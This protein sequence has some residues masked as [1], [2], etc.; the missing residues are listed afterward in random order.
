MPAKQEL[1]LQGLREGRPM[2]LRALGGS[3]APFLRHGDIVTIVPG[4]AVRLGDII[5]THTTAGLLLHRVV[6][7]S[8]DHIITKGD[9]LSSLD[10]PVS[11][12]DILGRAV[13]RDHRGKRSSLMSFGARFCGL[14]FSLTLPWVDRYVPWVAPIKRLVK[15]GLRSEPEYATIPGPD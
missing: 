6:R 4:P 13:A 11:N 7:K 15:G 5:L 3:M 8:A 14:G 10:P 12:R 1:W 2:R 9:R